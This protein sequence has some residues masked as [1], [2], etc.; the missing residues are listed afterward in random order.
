MKNK[1][2]DK[3]LLADEAFLRGADNLLVDFYRSVKVL[4]EF[5]SACRALYYIG[6]AVT[7]FGSARFKEYHRYY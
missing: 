6:P 4:N 5:V 3:K 2:Q 1:F 7:V